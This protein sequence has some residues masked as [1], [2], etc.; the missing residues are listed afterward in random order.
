[1]SEEEKERKLIDKISMQ[2]DIAENRPPTDEE[3]IEYILKGGC[4]KCGKKPA[5]HLSAF[6]DDPK[7]DDCFKK[8]Y[9]NKE[10]YNTW[11]NWCL[12]KLKELGKLTLTE[13][14][15]A[16]DYKFSSSMN[17]IVKR[18]KDKLKI[19]KFTGRVKIYEIREDVIL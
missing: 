11:D 10:E 5:T 15:I 17:V 1:M 19:T 18:N 6:M 2:M 9:E 16:M 3:T 8:P 13:W 7:C 4:C 14:A 12:K